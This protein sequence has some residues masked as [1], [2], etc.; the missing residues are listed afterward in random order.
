MNSYDEYEEDGEIFTRDENLIVN[1]VAPQEIGELCSSIGLL[2]IEVQVNNE[3][4]TSYGTVFLCDLGTTM[5]N[6]A[7]LLSAGHNFM[8]NE[9]KSA[10]DDGYPFHRF[11]IAF[12]NLKGAT[13]KRNFKDRSGTVWMNLAAFLSTDGFDVRLIHS[14]KKGKADYET[15]EYSDYMGFLLG[16]DTPKFEQM[17]EQYELDCLPI[18]HE[19]GNDFRELRI[20]GH[21]G[22]QSR[23]NA[24]ERLPLRISSHELE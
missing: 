7:A 5:G 1:K 14:L 2:S 23:V 21:S 8:T 15:K 12:R 3:E 20:C 4:Q 22:K 19:D 13:E 10:L 18:N 11:D 17:F 6:E 9:G 24:G 16:V